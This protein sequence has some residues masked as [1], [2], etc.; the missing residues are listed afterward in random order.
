MSVIFLLFL[1]LA[2]T[3][4]V[5]AATDEQL[6]P[7]RVEMK[8]GRSYQG[9]ILRNDPHYLLFQTPTTEMKLSKEEIRR[10]HDAP[11]DRVFFADITTKGNLPSWRSIVHDL[12]THDSI[13]F[14]EQIP[15]TSIDNGLL[16]NIPYLSFRVNQLSELN[17]YGDP[18]DP[19]AIEFGIL[20][21]GNFTDR[22]RRVFREFIAGHLDTREQIS[23]LYSLGKDR[24]EAH[25]DKLTFR[26]I[27]PDD[28]DGYGGWW[29]VVYRADKIDSARVS[30]KQY[31]KVTLPFAQVNKRNGSLRTD[32]ADANVQWLEDTMNMIGMPTAGLRGFYRDQ[33]GIFRIIGYETN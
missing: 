11:D 24:R 26:L 16:R 9:L 1:W 25:A 30:N 28:A 23:A 21:G 8:D 3:N 2:S 4:V 22:R 14:F 29:L 18:N 6:N 12:R 17:V 10:I 15:A 13:K 33:E 5:R 19:V 7:D 32:R 27:S 31:A 20:G